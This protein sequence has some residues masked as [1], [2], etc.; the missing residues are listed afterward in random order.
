MY[1]L[2]LPPAPLQ[3]L[4]PPL[5]DGSA[6]VCCGVGVLGGG[7]IRFTKSLDAEVKD[8]EEQ[9]EGEDEEDEEDDEEKREE[10]AGTNDATYASV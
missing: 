4:W 6:C 8:R 1:P 10:V 3:P 2:P 5:P 9:K 7:A